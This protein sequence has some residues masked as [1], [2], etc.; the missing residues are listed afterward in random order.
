MFIDDDDQTIYVADYGNDCIVEWKFNA[1][2]GQIIVRGNGQKNQINELK[3][4]SDVVIDKNANAFII[5]DPG[6]RRVIR[7]SRENNTTNGET[8]ISDI[9]CWGLGIDKDG[10][11]Y[12]CDVEKNE[13][14]RWQIGETM[15]G[16]LVAGGNGKGNQLNQLHWPTSIFIDDDYSLY[17][18][19]CYNH[20]VMKWIKNAQ[21]GILVAGGHG[22]GS[23]L[24]QLHK[25]EGVA[26]D[27]LRRIYVA[28]TYNHR[29]IRWS[30]G[31]NQGKIIIGTERKGSEPNRFQGPTRLCFDQQRN[32]YVV[33]KR[34]HRIQKF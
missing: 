26:V 9:D 25:P 34:N 24:K 2:N 21:E 11:L 12:T 19:D 5:A 31:D 7:W 30:Y 15:E 33:D 29:V 16:T 13:I 27:K 8:I 10:S 6:N 32:L 20:R 18:S 1:I 4:L 23:S 28:D 3:G 14:K 17:I 22:D